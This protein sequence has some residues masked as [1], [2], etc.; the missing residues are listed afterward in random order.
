LLKDE[1]RWPDALGEFEK[2]ITAAPTY[3]EAYREKG[4]AENKLYQKSGK[5]AGMSNGLASL[6]K[7]VELN[8][9]DYD[10]HASLGGALKRE[11]NLPEALAEYERATDVSRGHS[12]PLL[13][14]IKL[15]AQIGGKLDIDG[16]QRLMM[17]RA[18]RSLR[19][20]TA[21]DPPYDPPW[22]FFDLAEIRLYDGDKNEFLSLA[23]RGVEFAH[24]AW[25]VNTFRDSLQLLLNAGVVLP[26]LQEGIDMLRAQAKL[27]E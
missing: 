8:P 5:P 20:Q 23:E 15:K 17:K 12:Y 2:A 26:G 14:A 11:G 16:K 9:D 24:H 1:G 21:S 25:E 3:A 19:A 22:S 18:E 7:A 13:N 4:I 10:A 6:T 27:L